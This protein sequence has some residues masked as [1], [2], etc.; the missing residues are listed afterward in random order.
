MKGPNLVPSRLFITHQSQQHTRYL[1]YP[2]TT[3]AHRYLHYPPTTKAH[4]IPTLPTNNKSTQ[5][6]YMWRDTRYVLRVTGVRSSSRKHTL[7]VKDD[8]REDPC[9][10]ALAPPTWEAVLLIVVV[11]VSAIPTPNPPAAASGMPQP[12]LLAGVTTTPFPLAAAE[13]VPAGIDDEDAGAPPAV[14]REGAAASPLTA[15]TVAHDFA[16][17]AY[18][19]GALG[20]G[21]ARV[22]GEA[23]GAAGAAGGGGGGTVDAGPE[24]A[25]TT[26]SGERSAGALVVEEAACDVT[27]RAVTRGVGRERGEASHVYMV[28]LSITFRI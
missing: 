16:R 12:P 21:G 6:T 7:P 1:H 13:P 23:G 11:I 25:G 27:C 17:D 22:A 15:A 20:A 3:R 28:Y 19:M 9:P 18:V 26:V 8:G 24:R 14:E 2:P 10:P 4:K 5:D